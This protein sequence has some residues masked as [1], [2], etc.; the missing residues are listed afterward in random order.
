VEIFMIMET[1]HNW[2]IA[3]GVTG[4]FSPTVKC[5][6]YTLPT[7]CESNQSSVLISP[8]TGRRLG[9]D[10]LFDQTLGTSST[11]PILDFRPHT[12]SQKVEWQSLKI[13]KRLLP[14]FH[15]LERIAA[16]PADWD[17]FGSGR[18]S[19]IA[20]NASRDLIWKTVVNLAVREVDGTPDDVAPLSGG[21]VQI[22]WC[23]NLGSIEVE[24]SADGSYGYLLRHE[25]NGQDEAQEADNVPEERILYLISYI[26]Q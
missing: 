6:Q 23:G 3:H 8:E 25:Q 5:S 16:L 14:V 18:A 13:A 9:I 17:T 7:F 2:N 24:V 21:G 22:E 11:W 10:P 20:I 4:S 19:E 26:F 12:D 15:N 1:N